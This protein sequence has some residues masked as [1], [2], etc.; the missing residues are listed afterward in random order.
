MN[1]KIIGLFILAAICIVLS[2]VIG[3]TNPLLA[4][5]RQKYPNCDVVKLE[6]V[7]LGYTKAI[8]QCGPLVKEIRV[9]KVK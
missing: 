4:H 9:K 5:L 7:D 8:L 6:E 1:F 3:C 2:L